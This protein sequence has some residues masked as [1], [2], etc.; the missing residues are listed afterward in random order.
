MAEMAQNSCLPRHEFVYVILSH[1]KAEQLFRLIRTL[2]AS[3]PDSAI[4]LHHDAK[5]VPLDESAL[6]EIGGIYL[7][8]PRVF[9]EWGAAS[10][11]DALLGSITYALQNL[12][13]SWLSVLSAQDYPLR[14]LAAIEAELRS[15]P[16]DAFVEA[17][18]TPAWFRARYYMQYRRL[19]RFRYA[20]RFPRQVLSAMDWLCEQFNKRQ[21]LFRIAGGPRDTSRS[22]GVRTMSHPFSNDFAC[23]KGSDWFILSRRAVG[24]LLAFGQNRP[25]VL[26]YYRRT[27]LSCESYYQSVLC[28]AK[29]LKICYDNRRFIVWPVNSPH[30]KTL[31]LHDL[32]AMAQ[33]GKD[34]GRKFDTKADSAVL[35]ALDL[36][37]LGSRP[38]ECDAHQ[39]P[40]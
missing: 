18:P 9:V 39:I 4:L 12:E 10:Q 30:P 7:V 6:L 8:K 25:K 1:G 15:S 20:D 22:L 36:R 38:K 27:F 19:P 5:G 17:A 23:F 32:D 3:S 28:N 34:F 31:T 26:E 33:S 29:E 2:R 11:L 14:P 21:S 37:I 16:Y 13:F 40:K 35:D 24:Y